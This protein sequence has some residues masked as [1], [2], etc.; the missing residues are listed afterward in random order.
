MNHL[1]GIN[2]YKY[3]GIPFNKSLD[4]ELITAKMNS[5]INYMVNFSF[6]NIYI[7]I[8]IYI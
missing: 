6:L 1:P 3:L 5:K 8:Y 2:Q 7:Y 4:L